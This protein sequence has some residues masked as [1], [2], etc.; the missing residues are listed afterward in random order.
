M[1]HKKCDYKATVKNGELNIKGDNAI[2]ILSIDL[3]PEFESM[4]GCK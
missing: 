1:K 3:P 4:E 2:K